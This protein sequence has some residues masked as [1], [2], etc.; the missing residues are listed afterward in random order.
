M[1]TVPM[2][3]PKVV[4]GRQG[5][6]AGAVTRLVAFAIDVGVSWGLFLLGLAAT[7]FTVNLI[8][9]H[10]VN[11]TKHN[12]IYLAL[13]T[14]WFFFYFSY[15]CS[16]GGKTI[17]MALVGIRVVSADG[18]GV[19]GRQAALRTL[20]LPLSFLFFGLGFLGILTS[21]NR[22]ALHDYLAKTAVVY[23]WDA[24]A[25]RMRWLAKQEPTGVGGPSVRP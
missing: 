22:H 8:T 9:G 13:A 2:H 7:N 23:S 15:Q 19:T 24:R 17:G 11:F 1:S 14:F 18:S 20:C 10:S 4:V 3:Q 16:L 21:P 6:Y 5:Q 12:L 25:A